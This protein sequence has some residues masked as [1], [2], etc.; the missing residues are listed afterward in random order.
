[1]IVTV[2]ERRVRCYGGPQD[3]QW[4]TA[5]VYENE[6][7][8]VQYDHFLNLYTYYIVADMAFYA[9]TVGDKWRR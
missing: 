2:G 8:G 5:H 6:D 3:G 4:R 1:M 7:T 9:G